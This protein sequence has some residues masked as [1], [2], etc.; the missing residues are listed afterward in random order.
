MKNKLKK[1]WSII[2]SLCIIFSLWGLTGC[3]TKETIQNDYRLTEFEE[4]QTV[5]SERTDGNSEET[6]LS[7]VSSESYE[8]QEVSAISDD[9]RD[10]ENTVNKYFFPGMGTKAQYD[11]EGSIWGMAIDE[12][13]YLEEYVQEELFAKATLTVTEVAQLT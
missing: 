7:Q 10:E 11:Y 9:G 12:N 6:D 4:S 5:S 8:T 3:N 2:I 13:A 1:I